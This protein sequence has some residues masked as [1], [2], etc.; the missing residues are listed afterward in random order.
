M[1]EN[2]LR[3][4]TPEGAGPD[5]GLFVV[6][7]LAKQWE[8]YASC[9]DHCFV[10]ADRPQGAIYATWSGSSKTE[11]MQGVL[12]RP[13]RAQV[14][15]DA[16]W[17][18]AIEWTMSDFALRRCPIFL[19]EIL[20]VEGALLHQ[21][22]DHASC[23][24]TDPTCKSCCPQLEWWSGPGEPIRPTR[25]GWN[26]PPATWW[27]CPRWRPH[28]TSPHSRQRAAT[29]A[30]SSSWKATGV[31]RGLG[32]CGNWLDK[33]R[34]REEFEQL[35]KATA[36]AI[37]ERDRW[38]QLC[39]TID[40]S[41]AKTKLAGKIAAYAGCRAFVLAY[42][43]TN[44]GTKKVLLE[45][46]RVDG[47]FSLGWVWATRGLERIL[48]SQESFFKKKQNFR[49]WCSLSWIPY[50]PAKNRP[51]LRIAVLQAKSFC[52]DDGRQI[53]WNPLELLSIPRAG[54]LA[55]LRELLHRFH[56]SSCQ[57][58]ASATPYP[59]SMPVY[60]SAPV[61]QSHSASGRQ[62]QFASE[63]GRHPCAPIASGQVLHA[64]PTGTPWAPSTIHK[65]DQ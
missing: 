38:N 4:A 28:D 61:L 45:V 65:H 54:G 46:E 13:Q 39:Q 11:R 2:A 59:K 23:T 12:V 30:F 60:P 5:T 36:Q 33:R 27:K 29:P 42:T 31:L 22:L 17:Q 47:E 10:L 62:A 18:R 53:H 51:G 1:L 6:Q 9:L 24:Q 20:A 37:R 32:M 63:I 34:C 41:F 16:S 49:H 7:P 21:G 25:S 58:L 15:R 55:A 19:A 35:E 52:S 50:R 26:P 57:V 14:E 3:M 40:E 56:A 48:A 44:N 43:E 64:Q 8:N